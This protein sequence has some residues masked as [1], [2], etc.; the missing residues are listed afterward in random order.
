MARQPVSPSG[1]LVKSSENVKNGV[2]GGVQTHALMEEGRETLGEAV[3]PIEHHAQV[4]LI[5]NI[6]YTYV[7]MIFCKIKI[8][9]IVLG[10]ASTTGQGYGPNTTRCLCRA[11][12]GTIKWVVPRVGP[13]ETTHLT[14]YTSA[15]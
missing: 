4:F 8:N 12:P 3:L 9:I 10:R 1:H 5:F 2:G 7:Y 6:N 11:G 15:R 13:A 14:I